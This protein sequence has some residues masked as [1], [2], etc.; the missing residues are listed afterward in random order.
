MSRRIRIAIASSGLGRIYR[1]VEAWA[2]DLA[3]A[4]HA[5]GEDVTLYK[6]GGTAAAP[7]ERVVPCVEQGSERA[8]RFQS[9][10]P[11][12]A[13]RVGLGS[14]V[15]VEQTTFA[16][17]LLP[18]LWR[19]RIDVL[20]VQDAQVAVVAQWA[21]RLGLVRAKV[22]LGHGTEESLDFQR[23]IRFL[24]HLAP[25]HLEQA[26]D[27]GA[28]RPEWTAI[29][30]FV[31]ADLFRPGRADALRAELG[32]PADHIVALT[33]AAIKRHHKRVDYLL[34]E[35][36][37]LRAARPDLPV[38]LVI[39]G[40]RTADTDELVARGRER[41]GDRV[42]FLVQFPRERMPDLYRAA[43][44]FVLGSLF[45]MMPL[46]V[47]EATATG[48]PCVV[49]AHPVLQWMIG[50]GGRAL[51]L[52]APGA[53]ANELAR[54]CETP[55]ARAALGRAGRAHCVGS[56]ARDAVVDQILR[57]YRFVVRYANGPRARLHARAG[58]A[59]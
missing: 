21:R 19:E 52:A 50:P 14:D 39:A 31:D 47:L 15:Q 43:D 23:R 20:H 53:L 32:I 13:W 42:R 22:I 16:L 37:T 11:R 56:F 35:F 6:G 26:R 8:R 3:K 38:T 5:R 45:E 48:L 36:E 1:G 17:N 4:L 9:W 41:L 2:D 51:D 10:L 57:Y 28:W 29:P 27:A 44:V 34:A 59:A 54:L 30:N 18:R 58:A 33:S 40:G 49:N 25:W 46:A 24:Q 12:G 7:Y 55:D